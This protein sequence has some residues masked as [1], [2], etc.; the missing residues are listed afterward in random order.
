[1]K[2]VNIFIKMLIIVILIN[3]FNLIIP[4]SSS[5]ALDSKS[6]VKATKTSI[7]SD[8]FTKGDKWTE[9]GK[10]MVDEENLEDTSTDIF[11]IVFYIG[12]AL[13]LIVGM[14]LGIQFMMA[15][16]ENKAKIKEALI[17]YCV[18]CA[19]I[20]GGFGIWKIAVTVLNNLS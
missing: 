17:P 11:S 18:G 7:W 9:K 20:F 12:M 3:T 19:V 1:M 10:I 14:I 4:L 13:A 2:N 6:E 5:Y 8:I 15:S 16:T